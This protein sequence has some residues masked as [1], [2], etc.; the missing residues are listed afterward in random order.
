MD[1][2]LCRRTPDT[3]KTYFERA[4]TPEIR[5]FLPQKAKSLEEALCDYEKTLLPGA[6]SYGKTIYANGKY[7]GDIW[8]YCID[9]NDVPNA[10]ISYCIFDE[11]FRSKGA[12]T[13]ALRL[14]LDEIR[15]EFGF[16]SVGAFTFA[17][18]TASIKV[19]EKNGF[20][21]TEEFEESGILSKYYEYS[22]SR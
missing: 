9:K 6:S 22:F 20:A 13:K 16:T 3:V 5:K 10:M 14:F 4:S 11:K 12:A 8:C 2:C 18:N 1:I 19:L 17:E 7:I 21:F 15:K